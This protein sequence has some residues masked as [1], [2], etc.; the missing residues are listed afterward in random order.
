MYDTTIHQLFPRCLT[1]IARSTAIH[2]L[3]Y[4]KL[5]SCF[6]DVFD[7]LT[8]NRQVS[9]AISDKMTQSHQ[10]SFLCF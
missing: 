4:H 9:T 6:D 3:Y 10:K 7:A 1:I 5:I 2:Q 8:R